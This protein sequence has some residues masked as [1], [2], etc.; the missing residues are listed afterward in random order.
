MEEKRYTVELTVD[1]HEPVS[2][3]VDTIKWALGI[4]VAEQF[5]SRFTIQ[6]IEE[7]G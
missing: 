7:N 4:A 3:I 5:L 1:A 2:E 6:S